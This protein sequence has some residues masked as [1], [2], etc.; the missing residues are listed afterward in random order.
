MFRTSDMVLIA[1]MVAAA[2][3]TYKTK[4]GAEDQLAAVRTIERQIHFEEDSIDLLKADWSLLT[5]PS[6][7]QR[8]SETYQEDLKLQPVDAHQFATLAEVPVRNLDIED[9]IGDAMGVAAIKDAPADEKDAKS[10]VADA[11]TDKPAK[12]GKPAKA[13]KAAKATKATKAAKAKAPKV[14]AVAQ[15]IEDTDETTTG[16]VDE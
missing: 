16:A 6:R 4:Q 14:D 9:I 2:A 7:L 1:V 10:T 3:F 15:E 11:K 8:L 12:S 5:Q 13:S